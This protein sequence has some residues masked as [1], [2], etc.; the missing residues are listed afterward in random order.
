MDGPRLF[1]R[2]AGVA[3]WC[4]SLACRAIP[5]L[6]AYMTA[7]AMGV[8]GGADVIT[9]LSALLEHFLPPLPDQWLD[10]L[11]LPDTTVT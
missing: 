6:D 1:A 8:V 5:L 11:A 7:G 9:Q 4:Q 10:T 3:I 2:S